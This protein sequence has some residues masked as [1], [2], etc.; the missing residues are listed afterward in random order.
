MRPQ[1]G[2][3]PPTLVK[4]I[5]VIV[6]TN[7]AMFKLDRECLV[8]RKNAIENIKR[9]RLL[10]KN[11]IASDSVHRPNCTKGVSIVETSD[12]EKM[13]DNVESQESDLGR[14]FDCQ[15]ECDFSWL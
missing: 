12:I 15:S 14:S 8:N 7:H 11:I 4:T 10:A 13:T 2:R 1:L 5:N 3:H 9:F 6:G